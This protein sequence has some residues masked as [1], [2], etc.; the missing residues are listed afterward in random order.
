[1]QYITTQRRTV[2]YVSHSFCY[3]RHLVYNR[4]SAD[5]NIAW[6]GS[7]MRAWVSHVRMGQE[8][9]P[10]GQLIDLS[11]PVAA[12]DLPPGL[13]F[14]A[15]Q[16]AEETR[17]PIVHYHTVLQYRFYNIVVGSHVYNSLK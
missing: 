7:R 10:Q 14:G 3:K 4:G 11:Q 8:E 2:H 6:V 5:H 17:S 13:G 15:E 12:S 1:M 9:Q 16:I